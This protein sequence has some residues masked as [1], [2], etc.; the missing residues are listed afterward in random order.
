VVCVNNVVCLENGTIRGL[1]IYE[2][3]KSMFVILYVCLLLF[4][5]TYFNRHLLKNMFSCG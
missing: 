5:E 4:S 3:E 1:L 2:T